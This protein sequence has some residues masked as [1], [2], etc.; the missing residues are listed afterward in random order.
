MGWEHSCGDRARG[1]E[2]DP[3]GGMGYGTLG[4]GGTGRIIKLI[5]NKNKG[6]HTHT[7]FS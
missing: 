3:G 6:T 5:K 7:Y 2:G 1:N 4:L